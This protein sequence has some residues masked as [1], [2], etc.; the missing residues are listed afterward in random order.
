MG[1]RARVRDQLFG[2]GR[3][4]EGGSTL[5]QQ[6]ARNLFLTPNR[7]LKRK[8][9]EIVLAY[10]LENRL[11]KDGILELYL[12][13]V[14]LGENAFGIDKASR[15]YFGKPASQLTLTEAAVLAGLPKAPSK[16]GPMHDEGAALKRGRL[17]LD[18]MRREGWISLADERTAGRSNGDLGA[19]QIEGDL[20][21]A[22]DLAAAQGA[23]VPD[24]G[25]QS[26]DL[27]VRIT[28]DPSL[29]KQVASVVRDALS[30]EGRRVGASQA[31]VVLLAPDG[32]IRALI[33]GKD[34]GDSPFDRAVQARRQPGSSFKPFVW[35]TALE[36]GDKPTDFR[37]TQRIAF[38]PWS[39][40]DHASA[41]SYLWP[42]RWRSPATTSPVRLT[43]EAGAKKVAALAERFP[44]SLACRKSP[45][46]RLR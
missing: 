21:W 31:A 43:S 44:V 18:R 29:Q 16:L 30:G 35:A 8:L 41:A 38:G 23:G 33:G 36:A 28:I 10:Q 4:L 5:D 15:A 6:L 24:A 25:A 42:M 2:A 20:G 40:N 7:T 13:R 27:I 14:Y 1:H 17:V 32:A 37:S 22:Y 19:A 11:G 34:H 3:T 12:N 45:A 39:P 9:Q 26:G 46:C